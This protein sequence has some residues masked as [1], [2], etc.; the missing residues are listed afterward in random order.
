MIPVSTVLLPADCKSFHIHCFHFVHRSLTLLL[1]SPSSLF[2]CT[3]VI[4]NKYSCFP[5]IP[6]QNTSAKTLVKTSPAT[7]PV[8]GFGV[9]VFHPPL[10]P[11]PSH[12]NILEIRRVGFGE[13]LPPSPFN[14][15]LIRTIY[16]QPLNSFAVTLKFVQEEGD[17]LQNWR[18]KKN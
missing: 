4:T 1:S 17:C 3:S 12:L 2:F 9:I 5:F 10:F 18:H 6:V 15:P 11:F 8:F 16:F 7:D 14:L 13:S